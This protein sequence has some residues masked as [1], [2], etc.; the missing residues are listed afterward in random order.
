MLDAQQWMIDAALAGS[1]VC[2]IGQIEHATKLHLDR[3]VR[4][5]Q[6]AKWRGYGTNPE[7]I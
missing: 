2:D 4:S 5:G 3:L 7:R 1:V 6:I